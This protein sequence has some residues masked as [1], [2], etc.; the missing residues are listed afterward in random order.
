MV[1]KFPR[2]DPE[3]QNTKTQIHTLNINKK[4]FSIAHHYIVNCILVYKMFLYI[5]RRKIFSTLLLLLLSS[6]I[7]FLAIKPDKIFYLFLKQ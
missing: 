5:H 7:V 3:F 1:K 6:E 4:S 2:N